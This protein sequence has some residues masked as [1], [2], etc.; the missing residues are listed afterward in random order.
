[1]LTQTTLKSPIFVQW[2]TFG[3]PKK[4]ALALKKFK[5]VF[6]GENIVGKTSVVTK[7]M[8]G[9]FDESCQSTI[10]IDFLTKTLHLEDRTVWLQLWDTAGHERFRTITS[11]YYRGA[12]AL[13]VVFD[14]ADRQSYQDAINY[15]YG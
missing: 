9:S 2:A 13:M 12:H 10:G 3:N 1:M 8:Y 15:W 11:S 4:L 7:F 6:L 14:L 5:L